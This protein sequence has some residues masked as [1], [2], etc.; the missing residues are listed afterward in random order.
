MKPILCRAIIDRS[1]QSRD[2]LLINSLPICTLASKRFSFVCL[3]H[4]TQNEIVV[5]NQ[6]V[7]QLLCGDDELTH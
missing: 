5:M 7:I 2:F 6:L 1:N 4:S 3:C